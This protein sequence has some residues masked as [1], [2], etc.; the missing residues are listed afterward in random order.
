M[1]GLGDLPGGDF[2]SGAYGV[3]GDG[4]V[5]VGYGSSASGLEAFRWTSDGGMVGLRRLMPGGAD[6]ESYAFHDVSGDGSVDRRRTATLA[7][8][9]GTTKLSSGRA[10]AA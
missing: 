1:V 2:S 6:F 4:S 10:T 7:F 3:S 5:I 9:S 8:G